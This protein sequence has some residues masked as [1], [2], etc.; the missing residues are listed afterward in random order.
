MLTVLRPFPRT[1]LSFGPSGR[2]NSAVTDNTGPNHRHH[3]MLMSGDEGVA[4][5]S[6]NV[7]KIAQ[8]PNPEDG[9]PDVAVEEEE[10]ESSEAGMG[11]VTSAGPSGGGSDTLREPRGGPRAAG[12]WGGASSPKD[13]TEDPVRCRLEGGSSTGDGRADGRGGSRPL[14]MGGG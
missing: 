12:W 2:I 3:A 10:G 8:H 4:P 7:K 13:T 11:A 14:P 1:N 5:K 6:K 9:R